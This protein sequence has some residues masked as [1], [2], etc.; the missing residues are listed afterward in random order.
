MLTRSQAHEEREK[1]RTEEEHKI[2]RAQEERD[3]AT[4]DVLGQPELLR[5]IVEYPSTE[6]ARLVSTKLRDYI[7]STVK[8]LTW[9][10]PPPRWKTEWDATQTYLVVSW[11][12]S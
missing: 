6:P 5:Q 9:R 10:E 2:A 3:R 4:W 12:S 1:A 11:V 7:D 8:K